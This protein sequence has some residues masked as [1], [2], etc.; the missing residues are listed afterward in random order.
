MLLGG[1]GWLAIADA[2]PQ[3]GTVPAGGAMSSSRLPSTARTPS[4]ATAGPA[5]QAPQP[6]V[7]LR[8][9]ALDVDASVT[10]VPV[11]PGGGL[12]VPDDPGVLGWWQG[13]A[14][15]GDPQGSVVIDG[16]VDT[17]RDGRGALF[18]LRELR[19]GDQVQLTTPGGTHP[20][21][22][23]TVRSYAKASLPSE[24]FATAG[25]PRLVL[26]TCGGAFDR[27]TRQYADNIVVDAVPA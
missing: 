13:G 15:P 5:T 1:A 23:T 11:G 14:A 18:D 2:T 12:L 8:I 19:P 25:D 22:V 21:V 24:V 20:Y 17:A 10:P 9:P 3:V 7:R 16:H 6:P 26:I 4:T 27:H